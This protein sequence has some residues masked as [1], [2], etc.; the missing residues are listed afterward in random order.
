M[1]NLPAIQP[2]VLSQPLARAIGPFETPHPEAPPD[3]PPAWMMPEI[4]AAHAKL[5]QALGPTDAAIIARWIAPLASM[6]SRAPEGDTLRVRVQAMAHAL[7][8]LPLCCWTA[9]MQRLAARTFKFWPSVAE[10]AE[11]VAP[12]AQPMRQQRAALQRMMFVKPKPRGSPE[13]RAAHAERNRQAVEA[14]RAELADKEARSRA[15]RIAPSHLTAG[16]RVAHFR[17]MGQHATADA[18]ARANGI[19]ERA[20]HAA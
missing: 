1:S 2:L 14:M 9:D 16:Q 8:D 20:E 13:E 18:I 4:R 7:T 17:A 10:I 3:P 15:A 19:E 5:G 12:A 11:L 6:V